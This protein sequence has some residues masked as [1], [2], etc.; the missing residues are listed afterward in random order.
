MYDAKSFSCSWLTE[1][2]VRT[3]NKKGYSSCYLNYYTQS[4]LNALTFNSAQVLDIGAAYGFLTLEALQR[5]AFVTAN[6]IDA[7]HLK[8][9]QQN[10][11]PEL[12]KRLAIKQGYFPTSLDFPAESFDFVLISQVL[13]FLPGDQI[14]EGLTQAFKWLKPQGKIFIVAVSPYTSV[15]KGFLPLFEARKKAGEQWPGFIK[16]ISLYCD[17]E[18]ILQNNPPLINFLDEDVLKNACEQIGF[19]VEDC[20]LFTREDFPVYLT[21]G[22][23]ENVGLIGSKPSPILKR[24][25]DE[26]A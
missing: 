18:E 26:K 1:N 24:K 20:H 15:L 5:G 14:I 17:N 4:F 13:H 25:N 19:R 8:I 12:Q 22:T 11:P 7:Q 10:I 2:L 21:G 9:L 6:D 23:R 16:D 3:L